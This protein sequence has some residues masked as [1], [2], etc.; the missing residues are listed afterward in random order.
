MRRFLFTLALAF[1]AFPF[2]GPAIAQPVPADDS[3]YQAFGQKAGIRALMGD[4]FD[5]LKA[6]ART[7]PFFKDTNRAN[8][9]EQLIDQLCRESGG[10][11]EYKGATIGPAHRDLE[12]GKQDFNALVE[13]LQQSMD[14]K[15]IPFRE[16]NR[17]LARLAPM[18]REIITR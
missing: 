10:P 8:L 6:D 16:Q 13:V 2:Q 5:R 3:V 12:I 1:A 4:F 15:G 14:T 9:V 18:H 11:C 17:M 7:A